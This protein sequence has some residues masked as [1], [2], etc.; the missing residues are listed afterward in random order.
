MSSPISPQPSTAATSEIEQLYHD[1]LAGWNQRDAAKM[2]SYFTE[3]GQSIGFDGSQLSGRAAIESAI[4]Q[5]FAHHATNP[6]IAK[7]RGVQFL[8]SEVA[9]L[10]AVVGMVPHGQTDINPAVNA[11]QT[12]VAVKHDEQWRIVQFQ[13]TPAQFHGR[14]DLAQ[15]LT[16]ELRQLLKT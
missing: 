10:R 5:I 1:M 9:I 2:A 11:I 4:A 13:N 15:Q 12:L 7:V 8:A 6:Y 16:D 14:P 3:D